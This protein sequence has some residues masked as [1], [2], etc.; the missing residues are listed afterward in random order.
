MG[1]R[2]IK[3]KKRFYTTLVIII[4]L[5]TSGVAY[6]AY[7]YFQLKNPQD[8]F[9]PIEEEK[10]INIGDQFDKNII[11][12]MFVGFD[13]NSARSRKSELFRTDTNIVMTINL[14]E[15]TIDMVSIPRDSYV[16]IAH[17]GGKDK[18]NA[19]YGHG[20]LNGSNGEKEKDGFKYLMDTASELLG[21]IPIYHYVA[22]DMDVV[23]QIVDAIGGVEIEVPTDLY[24]EHGKDRSGIVVNKGYQKLDGEALLYYARYRHY[25]RGDIERAENQQKIM[26]AIFDSLKKSNMFSSL[27]KI[28]QS[29]QENV[30]TNLNLNQIAALA[31]F[32]K[33]M[34]KSN[35]NAHMM[36]GDFGEL[37]ALSYWIINQEERVNLIKELYG[38]TVQAEKQDPYE[39]KLVSLKA[40]VTQNILEIGQSA[41]IAVSGTTSLGHN[42][43]FDPGDVGY[44]SSNNKIVTVSSGGVVSAVGSGN[45]TITVKVQE[46]IQTINVTVK[47]LKDITP[48]VLTLKGS[49]TITIKA[50]ENFTDPG[51]IAR[52]EQDG[53]LTGSIKKSGTVNTQRA[54][55]YK[56]I[57]SVADK[58]GNTAQKIRTIIVEKRETPPLPENNAPVIKLNGNQNIKLNI[59]DA[60]TDPGATAIDNEDGNL[61]NSIKT[62]GLVNTNT[63]G[64]YT[65]TYTV[66]DSGGKT[67]SVV[68]KIIV[69]LN[70]SD[71]EKSR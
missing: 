6:G 68:R 16:T 55:S 62:H 42:K 58:S 12:I 50:G 48:P 2:K 15:K 49:E 21:D 70:K 45:G 31:L 28:Y 20:Y 61:T 63:E 30:K 64:T 53:N 19:A 24:K 69:E 56:I 44:S 22:V 43:L 26:M 18:F 57:Y 67:A 13:K 37:N 23:Q 35:I 3:N 71:S 27:P 4:V 38:V 52:D 33:D 59:G 36:P 65:I 39:E 1:K 17:S 51:A 9:S 8:L 34:D 25:P 41:H 60:F 32:A 14:R 29:V 66:E 5:L 11:N 47:Q 7:T 54:G 40:S 10:G 46:V